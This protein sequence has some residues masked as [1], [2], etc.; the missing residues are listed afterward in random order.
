[1]GKGTI[2]SNRRTTANQVR[3]HVSQMKP[4]ELTCLAQWTKEKP[5][6]Q[7]RISYHL[8]NKSDVSIDFDDVKE[9]LSQDNL[10]NYIIEFNKRYDN[11]GNFTPRVLF[12]D[13]KEKNVEFEDRY[14]KKF[15]ALGNLCFVVDLSVWMVITAYWNKSSDQHRTIDYSYYDSSLEIAR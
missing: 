10:E 13:K 1:M 14:G 6:D 8:Q 7:L 9:L 5:L 2:Y 4:S 15:N 12:R 11:E 3:K